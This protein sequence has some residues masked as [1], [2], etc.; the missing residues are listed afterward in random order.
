MLT[1]IW[2]QNYANKKKDFSVNCKIPMKQICTM[3]LSNEHAV[4]SASTFKTTT[5][6][7][8]MLACEKDTS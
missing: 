5:S 2:L 7:F 6:H 1:N 4:T 3:K 8:I